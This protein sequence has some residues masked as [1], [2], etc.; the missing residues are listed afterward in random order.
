MNAPNSLPA[1]TEERLIETVRAAV[2]DVDWV[3]GE[4]ASKWT[5]KYSRGRT[6][7]D[8]AATVGGD[9]TGDFVFKRRRVWETFADVRKTYHNLKWSHFY[10][11]IAWDDSAEC[12]AW[13]DEMDAT[14]AEMKA[15]R[16]MQHGDDL[17]VAA[18]PGVEQFGAAEELPTQKPVSA[19]ERK[20]EDTD[21]PAVKE[22][23]SDRADIWRGRVLGSEPS[24]ARPVSS[25]E[26]QPRAREVTPP[27]TMATL[28]DA[29]RA[30]AK[31]YAPF[32]PTPTAAPTPARAETPS[33]P[34]PN[35]VTA[36]PQRDPAAELLTLIEQRLPSL[37]PRAFLVAVADL[38]LTTNRQA[39]EQAVDSIRRRLLNG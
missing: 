17:T 28:A 2:S 29:E 10:A 15:W 30:E 6:D 14:V 22:D 39:V 8:F 7:A 32:K 5:T 24:A 27:G 19:P 33:R 38:V 13:A 11:A 26:S 3:V 34:T 35:S 4:C 21:G 18:D 25:P 9:L 16:R 1:E 37:D 31:A 36:P 20:P 23:G 12:L